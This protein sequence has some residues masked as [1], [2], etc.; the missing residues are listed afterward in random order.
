MQIAIAEAKSHFAKLI[1]KAEKGEDIVLTRYGKAVARIVAAAPAKK[2]SMIGFLK[3]Q[4]VV[5]DDFDD[6]LP[7]DILEAFEGSADP[8]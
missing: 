8:S 5:P 4:I 3:G 7:D 6:P 2:P 1:R